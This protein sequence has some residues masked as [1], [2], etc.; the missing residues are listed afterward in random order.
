MI[1]E[2]LGQ[3]TQ[4]P[5]PLRLTTLPDPEPGKGEILLR[6]RTFPELQSDMSQALK[7][8]RVTLIFQ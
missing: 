5:D 2:V 3:L 1:L 8:V 4:N 6:G 7:K